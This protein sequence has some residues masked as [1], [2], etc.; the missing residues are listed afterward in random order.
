MPDTHTLSPIILREY[1]IRGIFNDTLTP[2]DAH[3]IGR[4]FGS[5]VAEGGG[6]RVAL[7]YDG[8]LSSPALADA[9]AEGLLACG[10]DVL[11][12]GRGPS[13]ML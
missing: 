8:R 11:L 10:L 5:I 6:Q 7:G 4:A 12:V 2:A 9:V 1:D 3:A 13:P